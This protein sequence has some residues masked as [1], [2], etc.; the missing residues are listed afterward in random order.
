MSIFH[1]IPRLGYSGAASQLGLLAKY[2]PRTLPQRICCLGSD[3]PMARRLRSLGRDVTCLHWTRA[4]D[5]TPLWTLRHLLQDD[6]PDLIHVWGLKALRTLGLVQ[7][8]LLPR[9]LVSL[10]RAQTRVKF[11]R[12]DR[13]LLRQCRGMVTFSE[14]E[15]NT[16]REIGSAV[17]VIPPGVE[18]AGDAFAE[19]PPAKRILT[20]GALEPR[21]GFRDAI[22]A[23]DVLRYVFPDVRM[24]LVG[25][26]SQRA[27]LGRFARGLEIAGQV[28]FLGERDDV[29]KLLHRTDVVWAPTLQ[30]TSRQVV[31][32]AM[33]AGRAVV[34]ADHP[35][36][37]EIVTDG[38]TGFFAAPGDKIGFCKR[39]RG[40]FL[41][42]AAAREMG[43]AARRHVERHFRAESLAARWAALYA[44]A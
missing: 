12:L 18:V 2:L 31:L 43:D 9:T 25:D 8:R 26:G 29:P 11:S 38:K 42:P 16:C 41:D 14:A 7:R 4:F 34:A 24:T 37:R 19:A 39:S 17:T 13:W 20:I 23:L 15:A 3:G 36:L 5:P 6:R 33:A 10:S 30:G 28:E 32:E 27:A 40:L 21:K 35:A 44:A 1:L 22:W